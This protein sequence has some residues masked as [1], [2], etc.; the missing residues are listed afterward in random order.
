MK[1]TFLESLFEHIKEFPEILNIALSRKTLQQKLMKMGG[2]ND[3]TYKS[4]LSNLRTRK[5]IY[6]KKDEYFFT[7]KTKVWFERKKFD[8]LSINKNKQDGFWRV[9]TFDIPETKRRGRD[10]L[11][12]KLESLGCCLLQKSVFVTPFVCDEEIHFL[13]HYLGLDEYVDIVHA[14]S[15]GRREGS[16]RRLFK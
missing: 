2:Y 15:L 9:I 5:L 1:T 16:I 12:Y 10:L 6:K 4:G 13:T 14:S 7:H 3:K 8:F 11:R